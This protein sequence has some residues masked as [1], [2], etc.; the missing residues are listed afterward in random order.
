MADPELAEK[1]SDYRQLAAQLLRQ[2]REFSTDCCFNQVTNQDRSMRSQ[3]PLQSR[4]AFVLLSALLVAGNFLLAGCASQIA[5]VAEPVLPLTDPE[6]CVGK[7]YE[8]FM[9]APERTTISYAGEV[10]EVTADS[11]TLN[12]V[13]KRMK[14][15]SEPPI[16]WLGKFFLNKSSGMKIL[17]DPVTLQREQI[18]RVRE[19]AIR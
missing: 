13:T 8:I 16:P 5:D 4:M 15:V 17:D 3:T 10:T 9:S 12:S 11:V 1:Q 19:S 7:N 2:P 6:L 18:A 14:V